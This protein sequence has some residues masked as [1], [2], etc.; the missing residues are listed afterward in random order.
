MPRHALRFAALLLTVAA[1][2]QPKLVHVGKIHAAGLLDQPVLDA[3]GH[4][5]GDIVNV[6]VDAQGRPQAAV[7]DFAGFLGVGDRDVAV[8]WDTLKFTVAGGAMV[9]S[10]TLDANALKAL[11]VYTTQAPSVPVAIPPHTSKKPS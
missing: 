5:I 10:E 8:D 6:L 7:I 11:P 1:S 3:G 9:V 2:P 4:V